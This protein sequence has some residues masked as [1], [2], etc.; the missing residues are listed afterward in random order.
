MRKNWSGERLNTFVYGRDSIE[1]LHRY[2]IASDYIKDR[3]VLDIASG[4]G[5]GSNIMSEKA[6]FVY[7]VDIDVSA[8]KK[9]KYKYK[10]ANLEF[11]AGSATHIPLDDNSIDTVVSFETIE[12]HD[13]HSEMMNEIKRVLKPNGLLIISTPD[14][15]YY[16]EK[17]SFN[18][19]FHVKELYKKDF[20]SLISTNFIN[21]QLLNQKYVNGNS[22]IQDDET[23]RAIHFFSGNYREITDLIIDPLYLVAIA[24]DCVF[25]EQ[26]LTI[27]DGSQIIITDFKNKIDRVYC[28]NSYKLGHFILFPFKILKKIFK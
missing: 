2:A 26:K 4:E 27:F 17:R 18:N 7:G 10:S 6:K 22:I 16:S 1:H 21:T 5:Y 8:V 15:L 19:K 28:S 20:M 9:A 23:K 13:A 3:I 14:K 11:L 25:E 24:S 12:H